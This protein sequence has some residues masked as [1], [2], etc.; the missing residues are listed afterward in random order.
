MGQKP[1][2][3]RIVHIVGTNGFHYAA[4]VTQVNDDE[5]VEL[6]VFTPGA[7]RVYVWSDVPYNESPCEGTWHWPERE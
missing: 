7:A 4:I 3:G 6:A 2:I 1:S 5:T